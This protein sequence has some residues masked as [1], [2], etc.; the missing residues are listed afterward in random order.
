[1]KFDPAA[2]RARIEAVA[3]ILDVTDIDLTPF[4]FKG[5]KLI[6]THG[7]E[8]DFIAPGNSDA[9]YERHLAKQGKSAMD[10]FVRYYKV[11]G[12]SHGFGTFNAKYDDLTALD[13]WVES[14]HAPE[15]L[16]AVDENPDGRGRRR[17]MCVYPQWPKFTGKAGASVQLANF[18]RELTGSA[19]L[20]PGYSTSRI[21][22]R[23]L[24]VVASSGKTHH[25]I[26][27]R[28]KNLADE[29]PGMVFKITSDELAA[30]DRYEVSEYTRVQ[31][32][33]KSGLQA[34][35]YVRA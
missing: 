22:I 31:V 19:D 10:S 1:L 15:E 25:T 20:L 30:A 23:D 2:Y 24:A 16:L 14:G 26:A 11:P 17:P 35:V 27:E 4:R 13:N 3:K 6:L 12:L 32:T 5:G 29:V 8:D 33:L 34:W 18:G 28:S 21:A 7:T 9:Y